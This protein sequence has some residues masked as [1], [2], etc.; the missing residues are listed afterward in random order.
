MNNKKTICSGVAL[1]VLTSSLLLVSEPVLATK[2]YEKCY[3]IAKEG[4]NDCGAN[5][6]SCAGKAVADNISQEWIYVPQGTCSTIAATCEVENKKFSLFRAK[7]LKEVCSK[8]AEQEPSITG[9]S[10]S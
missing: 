2:K 9:G 6:H 7:K 10:L 3:G 5:G 1:S 8:V 4:K